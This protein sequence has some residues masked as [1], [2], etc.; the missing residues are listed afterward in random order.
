MHEFDRLAE[1]VIAQA[2]EQPDNHRKNNQEG[3]FAEAKRTL[4]SIHGA[5]QPLEKNYS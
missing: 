3:V 5:A 1:R 2:A 4:Q